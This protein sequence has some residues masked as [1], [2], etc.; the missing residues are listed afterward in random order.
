M[1]HWATWIGIVFYVLN[2]VVARSAH[3]DPQVG[4]AFAV[5]RASFS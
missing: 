1:T 4:I 5:Q 3:D 2:F